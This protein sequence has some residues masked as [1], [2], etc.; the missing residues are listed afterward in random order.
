VGLTHL[1]AGVVIGLLDADDAHHHA[2]RSALEAARDRRDAIAIAA[3]A[4][5]ECLVGVARR[6]ADAVT[7]TLERFERVPIDIVPLEAAAAV[8]AAQLRA[9]HRSLR[10]PDALVIAS[11]DVAGADRL[12]TTDRGWPSRSRLGIDPRI[13]RI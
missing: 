4:L 6:G 13:E 12:L 5:S 11:A 7:S 1:D 9:R 2:A 8:R 3:S 10:L